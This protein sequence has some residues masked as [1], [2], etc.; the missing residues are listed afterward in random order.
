MRLFDAHNHLHDERF[1]GVQDVLV[2][3]CRSAGVVRMVVN[4]SSPEDWP[5]VADMARRF[6]D[7]VIPA[8]GVHPWY[9]HRRGA[10]WQAALERQLDAFPGAVIGE[11]GL[12]RW[13]LDCPPAARAAVSPELAAWRAAPLEEQ[14]EVFAWQLAL[15]A[16]RGLSASIHCL[17]AWGALQERLRA[18]PRPEAWLLHSY[19]GSMDLVEPFVRLGGHFSFPG[20]FLHARKAR[21]RAA[22]AAV[23]VERLLVETDAPD[24]RLPSVLEWGAVPRELSGPEG[25]PLNHPANLDLVVEGLA[26]VRHVTAEELAPVLERNFARLFPGRA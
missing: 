19:G 26:R 25:R 12:D 24:Q 4:G 2:A 8:F 7:L 10:D 11:I 5:V 1:G 15:A 9:V 17:Q 6:P 3:A 18:G 13:I 14:G 20:Y 21:Q 22:F 16:R 23:P